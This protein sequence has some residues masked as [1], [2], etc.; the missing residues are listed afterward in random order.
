MAHDGIRFRPDAHLHCIELAKEVARRIADEAPYLSNSRAIAGRLDFSKQSMSKVDID[1]MLD[2][3]R[4]SLLVDDATLDADPW[5]LNTETCTIDLRTGTYYGHDPRDLITKVA[6]V[7]A[8][9]RSQCPTFLTFLRRITGGDED[10]CK[11]IQKAV[12]Y[13]LT[14]ITSEQVFFFVYGKGRRGKSTFI[15][16]IREMLADYCRHTPTETLLTKQYDNAISADLARL[17]GARMVTAVEANYNR[18]LDEAKIKAMT[19]GDPITAREL[20]QSFQ[21]FVALFKLWFLA[22]DRPRVR[23]TDDAIWRRIRV[24]PFDVP[25]PVAEVDRELPNK[26]RAEFPGILS[27]AIRGCLLWQKEG[28]GEPEVIR[29]AAAQW[30]RE[31]NHVKRF[32][33]E[34]IALSPNT[35]TSAAVMH[36]EFLTWCKQNGESPMSAAEL[37]TQLTEKC[38]LTH[39]RTKAGSVW[40]GV[41]IRA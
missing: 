35:Q 4:S 31:A 23:A 17:R 39:K 5:L 25:I 21:E 14:G 40:V 6:K 11:F 1:R 20:Y 30:R 19:G 37:K 34:K 3:A 2:L 27:W 15:S 12:G 26:L 28:L 38:D 10:L 18:S 36:N 7:K 33:T 16:I 9:P 32:F 29:E 13:S 41:T 22:N 8:K 24:I